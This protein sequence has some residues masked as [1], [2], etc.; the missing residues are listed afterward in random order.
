MDMRKLFFAPLLLLIVGC[1]SITNLTP[2][3]LPRNAAGL[4]PV[5]AA[6]N[7]RQQSIINSSIEPKVII[8]IDNNY[9]MRPVP[10]V[11]N[12]WETL[13][14]VPASQKEVY[15]RFKV[16]YL[17]KSIPNPRKDSKLS[18]EYKLEIID[19]K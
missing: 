13:V 10:L 19:P 2:T 6:W 3:K 18:P 5:E 4:Y 1:N 16:D 12:R 11:S 7:S 8:G 9:P 17:Y 15:Y 14:P